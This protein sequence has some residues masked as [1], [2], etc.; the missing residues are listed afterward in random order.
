MKLQFNEIN[1]SELI[2]SN[3]KFCQKI[4]RELLIIFDR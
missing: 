4:I 3:L 1:Y 2:H